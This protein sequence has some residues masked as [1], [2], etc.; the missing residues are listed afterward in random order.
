MD[1]VG[2]A[3]TLC[4]GLVTLVV[5]VLTLRSTRRTGALAEN[6]TEHQIE[7]QERLELI[8][9]L[10]QELDKTRQELD[11]ERQE[12][13]QLHEKLGQERQEHLRT[14][15]RAERAEQEALREAT[16]QL[17]ARM[18][19][20]LKELSEADTWPGGIRRVK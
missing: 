20:Y 15:Q 16:R 2:L 13:Q 14:Q 10:H 7:A 6:L 3:S 17:R 1:L 8:R 9:N 5:A 4:V 18:D 19:S 12:R 11:R